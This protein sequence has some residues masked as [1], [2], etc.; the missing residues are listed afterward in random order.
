MNQL[1]KQQLLD[2]KL[3][4]QSFLNAQ[5]EVL[6]IQFFKTLRRDYKIEGVPKGMEDWW[7]MTFPQF[8]DAL[9]RLEIRSSGCVLEDWREF[10]SLMREKAVKLDRDIKGITKE[11]QQLQRQFMV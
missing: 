1:S 2:A 9:T 11:V 10:F 5:R 3:N 8:Q 4:E 6:S 7:R